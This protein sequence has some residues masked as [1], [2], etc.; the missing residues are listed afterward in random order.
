M[1][2]APPTVAARCARPGAG[3]RSRSKGDDIT[4]IRGD[5]DDVFSHGFICPKGSTLKQLHDDPDRVRTPLVRRN[6]ELQPATWREAFEEIE[7]RLL[8]L[9]EEHGRDAVAVYLGN[10][11]VHNIAGLLYGRLVLKALGTSNLFSASTV[12]QRPKE[13]SSGLMF[14]AQLTVPVPDIDRTDYLLILGANPY[15]SNGSLATAPDWPGRLEAIVERG[16]VVVIDPRRTRTAEAATEHHPIR[17]AT[18]A[19]L[20]FAMAN[21]MFEEGLVALGALDGVVV[22]LDEVERV[23]RDFTPEAVAPVCGIDADDD[24]P[25]R[26]RAGGGADSRRVR[27]GRHLA[28]R[29]SARWRAGSS[30]CSTCSP[31]TSI[32]PAARCS[33]APR[34]ARRTRVAPLGTGAASSSGGGS[35]ACAGCPSRSVSCPPCAWPRRSTPTGRVGSALVTL[36]GNPV[37]S[38]P[39]GG[40]LDAALDSLEFMV[41]VDIYVNETTRHADVLLPAPSTL[42]K[43]HYDLALLQLAVR[44]V[45]N[46]SPPVV[47]LGPDEL[48]DWEILAKL[49]LIA[50][51]LGADADPA[52]ADDLAIRTLV[53][54]AV[55]D[56]HSPV[57]GRQ[58]ADLL[59]AL[60]PR[61]GPERI[62]DFMARTGPYGD[63][64]GAP[65]REGGLTL[66]LLIA[67][68]HGIDFGPL[69]P[70]LPEVLRTPSGM[71][72]LAPEPL[73]ADVATAA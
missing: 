51:G 71:V 43:G 61:R 38:T 13:I 22:G 35:A 46:Y 67:H 66:D 60:E 1:V 24:P 47:A 55:A 63:G 69:E 27:A 4:R 41:C 10:P 11:T 12:D 2:C 52:L 34:S 44:N 3:S 23:A 15:A 17:P 19:Y 29:S 21:T 49:A 68:P 64:F 59:A 25:A 45:A 40:R 48:D 9:L 6:G 8:P 31:A 50:Q 7:R 42:T 53:D 16:K 73:L 36:A 54:S 65:G 56:E 58:P 62:L 5:R 26:A 72:E 37:L 32:G 20:L 30:T 33:R 14:G 28:R 18:D 39:N 57:H 70:R